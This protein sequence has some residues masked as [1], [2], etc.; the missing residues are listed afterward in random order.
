MLELAGQHPAGGGGGHFLSVRDRVGASIFGLYGERDV[1]GCVC[2]D[3]D[4]KEQE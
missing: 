3:D 2:E 4:T 1:S